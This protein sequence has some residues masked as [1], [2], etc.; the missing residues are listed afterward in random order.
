MK[1]LFFIFFFFLFALSVSVTL[2]TNKGHQN[3]SDLSLSSLVSSAQAQS[4]MPDGCWIQEWV[5]IPA[6]WEPIYDSNGNLVALIYHPERKVLVL[7]RGT[8]V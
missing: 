6:Y 4:E 1:K 5:T 2:N 8:C 7:T 3:T